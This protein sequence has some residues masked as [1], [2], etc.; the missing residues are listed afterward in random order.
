MV[1]ETTNQ[2]VSEGAKGA[3]EGSSLVMPKDLPGGE[4]APRDSVLPKR[5][6]KLARVV[7]DIKSESVASG[8]GLRRDSMGGLLLRL[9]DL[10]DNPN[11]SRGLGLQI[12]AREVATSI[13]GL[14]RAQVEISASQAASLIKEAVASHESRIRLEQEKSGALPRA[15]KASDC[16][17]EWITTLLKYAALGDVEEEFALQ[18]EE[19]LLGTPEPKKSSVDLRKVFCDWETDS[20]ELY[21]KILSLL[22]PGEAEIL[23]REYQKIAAI[24]E[25][26]PFEFDSECIEGL[27]VFFSDGVRKRKERF[28]ELE[29]T[30]LEPSIRKSFL[31]SLTT[32]ELALTQAILLEAPEWLKANLGSNKGINQ[33]LLQH[34]S[35]SV[36][37]GARNGA[38]VHSI[39]DYYS[40]L[41]TLERDPWVVHQ[42]ARLRQGLR[43]LRYAV[44]VWKDRLSKVKA[45]D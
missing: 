30:A 9:R 22:T 33:E 26:Q 14:P 6:P 2:G 19:C 40:E 31:M 17:S 8:V 35:K 10:A 18:V 24:C 4:A 25:K 38:R 12:L 21:Q 45:S 34:W 16:P 37:G 13:E 23:R 27:R 15:R 36:I 28:G 42:P 32:L 7:C 43:I 39:G 1:L 20:A 3:D 44:G 29:Q 11:S 5:S 41:G